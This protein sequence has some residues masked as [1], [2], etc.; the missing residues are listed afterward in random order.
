MGC[1]QLSDEG[2][3]CILFLSLVFLVVRSLQSHVSPL[4]SNCS[5]LH[6]FCQDTCAAHQRSL[7]Q[8]QLAMHT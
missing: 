8:I 7:Q 2:F 3:P 6:M 5:H 4:L 1:V